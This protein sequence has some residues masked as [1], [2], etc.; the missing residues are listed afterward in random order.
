[1]QSGLSLEPACPFS[2]AIRLFMGLS[3]LFYRSSLLIEAF[4]NL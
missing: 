2:I 1:M 3:I 4:A